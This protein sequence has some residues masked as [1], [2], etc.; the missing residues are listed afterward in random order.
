MEQVFKGLA[1]IGL[2]TD[3]YEG[4]MYFYTKQL[5]FQII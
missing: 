1:H 4:T 5:P 2:F 3:D